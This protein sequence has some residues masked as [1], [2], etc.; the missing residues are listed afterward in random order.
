MNPSLK[1]PRTRLSRLGCAVALCCA[2]I[3][4][5][6]A[7]ADA[8]STLRPVVVTGLIAPRTL[9][10]EFAATSVITREDI[11]RSG[12]RDL[13]SALSRLGV[14]QLE[15]LGGP[16]TLATVR[17]RGADSRDTLVLI[18]GVPITDVTSG[19]AAIAQIPTDAIERIE[20]VRG[21]LSALHGANAT[22]GV[23]QV[24]TRRGGGFTAAVNAGVGNMATRAANAS[25]GA[26][27]GMFRGRLSV[28]G[29]RSDGFSAAN[30]QIAPNANPDDDGNRR[31]NAALALDATL[32]E[33]QELGADFNYFS[34]KAL[35]DDPS[36]FATPTDT[37]LSET[38]QRALA[39]RGSH[40]LLPDWTLAWRAGANDEKRENF[41]V[42][43]F[44]PF[45]FGNELHN[46]QAVIDLTGKPLAGLT[47]Q[48]GGEQL[49]Q[50]TDN[51]T[52]TQTSRRTNTLRA[53]A[54]FD[55]DWGGLQLNLRRDDTSDFGGANTG[56][57]GARF[58]LGR[59]LSVLT[60]LSSSF[61]PPTLDF[62]FFDCSPFG[63]ACSNPNLVPERARNADLALQ[64]QGEG[65]LLRAT[66]FGA[67]Y[68]NKIANDANFVPQNI[69]SAR[70]RGIELT[71]RTQLGAWRLDGEATFQ[72]P[73]DDAT[74][75]QLL[76]RPRQLLALRAGY[77]A[78]A[79]S[80]DAAL[81]RVGSRPDNGGVTLEAYTV[82]DASARWRINA[83][84][85]LQAT[86]ENLFDREYQPVYGYNGRPRGVFV[87]LGWQLR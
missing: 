35:Y 41:T 3:S 51:P 67:R 6:A 28:G 7:D 39:L 22:G 42:G 83:D 57:L 85:S 27:D 55:A 36:S 61:T 73:S 17:L 50:S 63:Y 12:V 43:A 76:R 78:D 82:L 26:G 15:Q 54:S 20:V 18:D 23:I 49:R 71:A 58:N 60:T 21:N 9:G 84:W 5:I 32:A 38:T 53:G 8:S 56:L 14:V 44:G 2:S 59:E 13:P 86:L 30:P 45:D 37:H 31:R 65:A 19:L 87:Q 52:Y 74:G 11:E 64:W 16:G 34:G 1:V 10:S 46:R 4:S 81:K 79:W 40:R 25:I 48:L 72:D 62:L 24:F 66:L 70:N 69:D 75:Q 33:G 77:D 68:E 80:A 29:E 47:V